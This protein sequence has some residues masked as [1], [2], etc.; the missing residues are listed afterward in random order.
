MTGAVLLGVG[1]AM[2]AP[3]LALQ[4]ALTQ[5]FQYALYRETAGGELPRPFTP[6][7]V[8]AAFAS[9][10]RLWSSRAA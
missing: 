7:D 5:L 3:L 4:A 8:G 9:R 10:R 2:I 1:I 6:A